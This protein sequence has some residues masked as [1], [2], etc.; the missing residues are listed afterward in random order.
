MVENLIAEL[1]TILVKWKAPHIESY[2]RLKRAITQAEEA[3]KTTRADKKPCPF[4]GTMLNTYCSV[5]N[6]PCL[7]TCTIE[8][9]K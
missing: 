6:N 8:K 2:L 5:I 1:K 7:G 4:V 3:L 9:N